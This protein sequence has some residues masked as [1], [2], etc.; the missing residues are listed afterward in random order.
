MIRSLARTSHQFHINSSKLKPLYYRDTTP[1][2]QISCLNSNQPKNQSTSVM[3][4]TNSNAFCQST[5][6]ELSDPST[7]TVDI[8]KDLDHYSEEV[9]ESLPRQRFYIIKR[10]MYKLLN[11]YHTPAVLFLFMRHTMSNQSTKDRR[12]STSEFNHA[13]S[14]IGYNFSTGGIPS[15]P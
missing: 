1:S 12:L 11:K 7:I 9:L 4:P 8:L 10:S 3:K 14:A 5:I 6:T 2:S 15:L 13:I